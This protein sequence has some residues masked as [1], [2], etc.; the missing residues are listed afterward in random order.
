MLKFC[1]NPVTVA[2]NKFVVDDWEDIFK[3]LAAENNGVSEKK[4][5]MKNK[6]REEIDL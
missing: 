5:L 1:A 3:S 2:E 6:D 4:W